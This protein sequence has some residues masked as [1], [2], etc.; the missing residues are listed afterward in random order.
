MVEFKSSMYVSCTCDDRQLL[1]V[2]FASED[3]RIVN[4]S[5]FGLCLLL[6]IVVCGRCLN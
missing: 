6:I 3:M 4:I 2:V 5:V 1:V